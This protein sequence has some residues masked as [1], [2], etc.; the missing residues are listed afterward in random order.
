VQ[1][2]VGAAIY[3]GFSTGQWEICRIVISEEP[4]KLGESVNL[5]RKTWMKSRIDLGLTE[6]EV[7][8]ITGFLGYGNPQRSVWFIGLEE[9]L[10]N[11]SDAEARDNLKPRSQFSPVMD[12]YA[13]HIRLQEKGKPMNIETKSG[14]VQEWHFMAKIMLCINGRKDWSD[15]KSNQKAI[16]AKDYIRFKLGRRGGDTF[17]TELSPIPSK[18]TA[19]LSWMDAFRRTDSRLK[20]KIEN[21]T[22]QLKRLFDES[23][24]SRVI[25]YGRR[26]ADQFAALLGINK[27]HSITG[28]ISA[29]D[30]GKCLLL[31]FFGQAQMR[32]S[33]IQALVQNGLL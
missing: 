11:S 14:F 5:K 3:T 29:S 2:G 12:L 22:K 33:D 26:A 28:R 25:C 6:E 19:D 21:R 32:D 31:P 1:G 16:L 23:A 7:S 17:M 20:E 10:G 27:W 8:G 4:Q 30:D 24:P 18:H 9:G 15:S 13:A